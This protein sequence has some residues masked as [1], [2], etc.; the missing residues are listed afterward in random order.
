MQIVYTGPLGA[1]R[2][3]PDL[4]AVQRGVAAD[5]PDEVASELVK[6]GEWEKVTNNKKPAGKAADEPEEGN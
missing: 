6:G 4:P 5:V 1:Q 3:S 2:P